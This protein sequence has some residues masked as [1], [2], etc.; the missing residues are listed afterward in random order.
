M[1]HQH[2]RGQRPAFGV[3]V[4][5]VPIVA[6]VG[7]AVSVE[8]GLGLALALFEQGGADHLVHRH[9]ETGQHAA[10]EHAGIAVVA[11]ARG[12]QVGERLGEDAVER[13]LAQA[14]PL[15]GVAQFGAAVPRP[16]QRRLEAAGL[17]GHEAFGKVADFLGR[18]TAAAPRRLD[19]EAGGE[20]ADH[21]VGD[22][23][24]GAQA[25]SRTRLR[26]G[27]VFSPIRLQP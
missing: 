7:L 25:G 23:L 2:V 19:L 27:H 12:Q 6:A 20:M 11:A 24:A 16:L 17:L 5:G 3:G 10:A 21:G 4:D 18:K 13:V 14:L 26:L 8:N 1:N 22:G 15:A 9:V